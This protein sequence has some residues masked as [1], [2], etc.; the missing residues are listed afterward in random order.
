[1][2]LTKEQ[3]E[4]WLDEYTKYAVMTK[5]VNDT[6]EKYYDE[7]DFD[8]YAAYEYLNR[9]CDLESYYC[10]VIGDMKVIIDIE[11]REEAINSKS[12]LVSRKAYL[13]NKVKVPKGLSKD[14]KIFTG[15][16]YLAKVL[17][18]NPGFTNWNDMD[19]DVE[20]YRDSLLVSRFPINKNLN[21]VVI[22]IDAQFNDSLYGV[23]ILH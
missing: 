22:K 19:D 23:F 10:W 15:L 9:I 2:K 3:Q 14:E 5:L 11:Y 16:I 1:M 6:D 8:A 18:C 4:Q 12:D 13:A 21:F 17:G 7:V 20:K